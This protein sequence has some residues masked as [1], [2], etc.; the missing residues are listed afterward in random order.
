MIP[1]AS[2]F[3]PGRFLFDFMVSYGLALCFAMHRLPAARGR[4]VTIRRQ[5]AFGVCIGI[6]SSLCDGADG[7]EFVERELASAVQDRI[8]LA[9]VGLSGGAEGWGGRSGGLG[10]RLVR[11]HFDAI[12]GNLDGED[13]ADEG[14][15]MDAGEAA[16]NERFKEGEVVAGGVEE[17]VEGHFLQPV[18]ERRHFFLESVEGFEWAAALSAMGGA[19]AI[20]ALWDAAALA[21]V[22]E[23]MSAFFDHDVFPPAKEKARW[24]RAFSGSFGSFQRARKEFLPPIIRIPSRV[25]KSAKYLG[26]F[27]RVSGVLSRVVTFDL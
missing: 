18:D 22:G 3:F 10:K 5:S 11:G 20:A 9:D 23:D 16:L 6:E 24:R 14:A 4:F 7:F 2:Y 12:G 25:N 17:F 1:L 26:S 19:K 21:A 27:G 15:A 8:E 13:G